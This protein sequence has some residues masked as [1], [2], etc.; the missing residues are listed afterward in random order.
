MFKRLLI[1][2]E[3][4]KAG[5]TFESLLNEIRKITYS[6]YRAKKISKKVY[7]NMKNLMKL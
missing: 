1:A 7:N 3:Q 4:V 2:I 6:L 5:N